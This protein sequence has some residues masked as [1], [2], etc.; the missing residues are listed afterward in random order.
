M[1][2]KRPSWN[3]LVNANAI[4]LTLTAVSWALEVPFRLGLVVYNEQFLAAILGLALSLAFLAHIGRCASRSITAIYAVMTAAAIAVCFYIAIAYPD[5]SFA[6]TFSPTWGLVV[7]AILVVLV[8]EGIR[9]TSGLSLMIVV[10]VFV[11]YALGRNVL[12]S[13]F[14]GTPAA[15]S[16]LVGYLAVDPNAILG[17]PLMIASTIVIAFIFMGQTL[18]RGGGAEFFRDISL[19]LLGRFRGGAGKIAIFSSMLF[20]LVSGSAVG[21]VVST[22]VMTIGIMKRGGFKPQVAAAIEAVAS[23]GGQILP[24][25]LGA[26]AFLMADFI[27][28]PYSSIAIAALIPALLYFL[29]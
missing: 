6:M 27:R 17:S 22:G 19:V 13:P 5:F 2:G 1:D 8:I 14:G 10:M 23:T 21:N 16:R 11:A 18:L 20:G 4:L 25:V 7:C 9:M 26:T 24:P 12:P 28:V 3:W 29:S 15:A